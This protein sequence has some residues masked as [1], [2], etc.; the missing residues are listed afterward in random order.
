MEDDDLPDYDE[1]PTKRTDMKTIHELRLEGDARVSIHDMNNFKTAILG[2]RGDL[3][4]WLECYDEEEVRLHIGKLLH[5]CV[6]DLQYENQRLCAAAP[7][8]L[9]SLRLM[10]DLVELAVPF[11]GDTLRRAR[12]AIAKATGEQP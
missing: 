6:A 9:E 11:E 1:L 3:N 2:G 12:A 7:D 4:G 5:L 8:L 10:V